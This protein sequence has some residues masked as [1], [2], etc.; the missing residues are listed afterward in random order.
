MVSASVLTSHPTVI[1][2]QNY[3]CATTVERVGS[4]EETI[5]NNQI[6]NFYELTNKILLPN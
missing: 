4:I 2:L 1:E 3:H 6:H 5:K